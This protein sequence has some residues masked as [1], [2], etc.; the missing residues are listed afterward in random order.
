MVSVA[1]WG[2][3]HT[4][5]L[6]LPRVYYFGTPQVSRGHDRGATRAF[7]RRSIS[8][9]VEATGVILK[10]FLDD[11]VDLREIVPLHFAHVKVSW[12]STQAEALPKD[13]QKPS[14]RFCQLLLC[15]SLWLMEYSSRR[16]LRSSASSSLRF[17]RLSS[18]GARLSFFSSGSMVAVFSARLF[19]NMSRTTFAFT[20]KEVSF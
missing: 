1:V 17:F 8:K 11:G 6:V 15:F 16:R 4:Y 3:T 14:I 13:L 9:I 12:I 7:S 18:P 10:G 19:P 20:L 2:R 5:R